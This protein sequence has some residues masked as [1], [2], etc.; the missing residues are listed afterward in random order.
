LSWQNSGSTTAIGYVRVESASCTSNCGPDDSYR[1]RVYETTG[2]IARFNMF[3]GQST[4]VILQN[5]TSRSITGMV[6]FWSPAGVRLAGQTFTLAPR[7]SATIFGFNI[8]ALANQSGAVTVTHDGPYAAVVG[9][10]VM[11]DA[12]GGF[13]FESTL[14]PVMR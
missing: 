11:L 10:S 1:I 9:K 7:A 12:A 4:V 14:V 3:N 2:R 8:P 5:T 13:A 6:N